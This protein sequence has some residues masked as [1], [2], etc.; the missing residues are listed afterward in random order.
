MLIIWWN[1]NS[2]CKI[3]L[4]GWDAEEH[5]LFGVPIME[6]PFKTLNLIFL[7]SKY[8]IHTCKQKKEKINLIDFNFRKE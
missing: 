4:G 2:D 7:Y 5:L 1:N 8:Y 6:E 3:D